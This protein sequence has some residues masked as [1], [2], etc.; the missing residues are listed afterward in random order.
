MRG[1][2]V[3]DTFVAS[4]DLVK[5]RSYS[6]TDLAISELGIVREDMNEDNIAEYNEKGILEQELA[7]YGSFDAYL[8]MSI[9]VK[10]KIVLLTKQLSNL[11]GN[12][13]YI[14]Y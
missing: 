12:L 2:L 4:Q 1:R 10:L 9:A 7:R 8:I 3:C 14:N 11:A 6:L 13:W 5:C